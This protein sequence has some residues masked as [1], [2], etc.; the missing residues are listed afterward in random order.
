MAGLTEIHQFGTRQIRPQ[1]NIMVCTYVNK[2]TCSRK[3][4]IYAL[5][6]TYNAT[7]KMHLYFNFLVHSRTKTPDFTFSRQ[8]S[9][10]NCC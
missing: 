7:L 8:L 9:R 1:Q 5:K 6:F 2:K 10:H 4:V 3:K